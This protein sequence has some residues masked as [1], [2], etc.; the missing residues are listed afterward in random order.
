MV[1]HSDN[2]RDLSLLTSLRNLLYGR[3]YS[4]TLSLGQLRFKALWWILEVL[5]GYFLKGLSVFNGAAGHVELNVLVKL[6]Q[7]K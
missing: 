6:I 2:E 1:V 5:C 3:S 7:T 4:I